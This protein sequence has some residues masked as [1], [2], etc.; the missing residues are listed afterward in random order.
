MPTNGISRVA[1]RFLFCG[2][3]AFGHFHPLMP[4]A[5]ALKAAGHEIAFFTGS[6][7]QPVIKAAGFEF[8]PMTGAIATDPAYRLIKTELSKRP[9]DLASEIYAYPRLFA[10]LGARVHTSEL[11][12]VARQWQPD[13]LIRE[14]G[15][16][17]AP[18]AA[19]YLGLPHAVVAFT[20]AIKGMALFEREVPAQLNPTREAWGLEPTSDRYWL[21]RYLHLCYAPPSFSTQEIGPE[22][23]NELPPNTHFIRPEFF[24]QS[25]SQSLPSWLG[26]LPQQPTIYLTLGTEINKEPE[27]YPRV[28]QLLIAGLRELPVN[29]IVTLGHTKDPADFGL[30]PPNV[31]IEQYIP[32]TLLLPHCDLMVMHGGSNTLLEALDLALP[33]VVVPLIA[34]QFFNAYIVQNTQIGRS[35]S[36]A[37]LIPDRIREVAAEVL[38]NPLYKHNLQ[39]LQQE[40][41]A[42]PGQDHAVALIEQIVVD[43]K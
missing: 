4:L 16:Y 18:I 33:V 35:V 40:M 34:D 7:R 13:M 32:Q 1:R 39:K 11:V 42:L 9:L 30:Q 31:H 29:L 36:L 10:G 26:Q 12:Q 27:L 5:Q 38:A 2:S 25:V 23:A 24:D 6:S 19:E 21:Y 15:H 43:R 41:H 22:E 14:A 3:S 28:L 17:A 37:E 20:S 8:F